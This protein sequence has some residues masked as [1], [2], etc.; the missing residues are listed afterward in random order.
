MRVARVPAE[1]ARKN[2]ALV[3]FCWSASLVLLVLL[4]TLLGRYGDRAQEAWEWLLPTITP[5]TLLI[6][7]A[8]AAD[9]FRDEIDPRSVDRFA[10]LVAR[11]LSIFYL[12]AVTATILAAPLTI[13]PPL[14]LMHMSNMWL[15]PLQG[16]AAASI[17][18]FFVAHA[19]VGRA[20]ASE[21]SDE[22]RGA[23]GE[24]RAGATGTGEGAPE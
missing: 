14:R 18:V 15:G 2:L 20:A 19:S 6:A 24:Q 23:A 10:F 16:I 11:G 7:G 3:W 12:F 5:V 1:T 22:R 4:Q 9:A 8:V 17:G 21:T 13:V